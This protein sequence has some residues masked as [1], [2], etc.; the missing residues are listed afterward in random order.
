MK[1]TIGLIAVTSLALFLAAGCERRDRADA[2]DAMREAGRETSEAM[3]DA[4]DETREA[5]NDIKNATWDRRADYRTSANRQLEEIKEELDDL[6]NKVEA[7]TKEGAND[8]KEQWRKL[9][10]ERSTLERQIDRLG[11]ATE[12]GWDKT[13][14]AV[15]DS[16]DKIRD[17][18]RDLKQKVS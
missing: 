6:G 16:I 7:N 18:M 1:K 4:R 3:R 13:R 12:D 8:L 5:W 9:T 11:D 17:E 14:D 2:G 10:D 15:G